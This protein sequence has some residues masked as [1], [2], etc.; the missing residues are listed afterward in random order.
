MTGAGTVMLPVRFTEKLVETRTI[1]VRMGRGTSDVWA[2][3]MSPR[4]RLRPT[5]DAITD[6]RWGDGTLT[7]RFRRNGIANSDELFFSYSFLCV[8]CG[9]ATPARFRRSL[10]TRQQTRN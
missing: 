9:V 2:C 1:S 3:C 4:R 7:A 10:V 8:K 6:T 5:C